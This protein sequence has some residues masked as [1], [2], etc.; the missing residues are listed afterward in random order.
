MA[1]AILRSCLCSPGL[2]VPLALIVLVS[3]SG[4]IPAELAV[5]RSLGAKT[6]VYLA[7]ADSPDGGGTLH[8]VFENTS[9]IREIEPLL[10]VQ[11]K[12]RSGI[13]GAEHELIAEEMQPGDR[14]TVDLDLGAI[15]CRDVKYIDIVRACNT[16]PMSC[17]RKTCE[18][19]HSCYLVSPSGLS[20]TGVTII[21]STLH[22]QLS[23]L[24]VGVDSPLGF[25][26]GCLLPADPKVRERV[27]SSRPWRCGEEPE[28][29]AL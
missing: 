5:N 8:W 7:C 14:G 25:L 19:S 1:T 17:T 27:L 4:C 12:T 9:G 21:T 3:V 13:H 29:Q 22:G 23:Y 28:F 20:Y 26:M 15:S 18:H 6:E 16:A 10:T 11:L 24:E 2:S